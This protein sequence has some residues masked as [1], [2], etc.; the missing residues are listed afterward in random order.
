MN[1][2]LYGCY[3]VN[4]P[5]CFCL[6]LQ[7]ENSMHRLLLSLM[8]ALALAAMTPPVSVHAAPAGHKHALLIGISDYHGNEAGLFPDLNCADDVRQV[9]L[10]LQTTFGF[11]P[12]TDIV[13]LTDPAHTTKVAILSAL[14]TLV[15]ETGPGDLVFIHYSGHGDQVVDHGKA[16]GQ[17]SAIVPCDYLTPPP[18]EKTA[19]NAGEVDGRTIRGYIERLRA[20]KPAQIVLAFDSCHSASAA[21]AG[22]SFKKRGLDMADYAA[23]YQAHHSDYHPAA[24]AVKT[25]DDTE[26]PAQSRG[27]RMLVRG[28]GKS[29][30]WGD[31]TGAGYVVISACRNA[32]CAYECHDDVAGKD[33]G[34]LSYCLARVL[35]QARPDTTYH[36]LFDQV[37]A[38]FRAKFTDQYPQLDGD[39][40]TT[41][42]GG[43]AAPPPASF[44]VSRILGDPSHCHMKAG[45]LQGMTVGSEFT[46]YANS[47]KAFTSDM[48]LGT[49]KIDSLDAAQSTLTLTDR[50]PGFKPEDLDGA[51]AVETAHNYAASPF[52]IDP[53]SIRRQVPDQ[54]Q[55]I[56]DRL[57][58]S[59]LVKAGRGTPAGGWDYVLMR[60]TADPKGRGP[61]VLMIAQAATHTAVKTLDETGV[62]PLAEQI[63]RTVNNQAKYRYAQA[64]G[65]GQLLQN[66]AY[67]VNIRLMHAAS[68]TE[69]GADGK[70]HSII[71]TIDAPVDDAHPLKVGDWFVIQVQNHSP[72]ALYVSLL[73][74]SSAGMGHVDVAWPGSGPGW[75]QESS[76]VP[77]TAADAWTT[78]WVQ[79]DVDRHA[80]FQATT[81]DLDESL[82]VIATHDYVDLSALQTRGPGKG[83]TGP[84]EQIVSPVMRGFESPADASVAPGSWTATPLSIQVLQ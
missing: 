62:V 54:A 71:K 27:G 48:R 14:D 29:S 8:A 61:K 50:K 17:D 56:L 59:G 47:A 49:A 6:K 25:G 74:L 9:S 33:M 15:A 34:R 55:A 37:D 57:K 21:R 13:T 28:P 26:T 2:A 36:Q 7:E 12:K 66:P 18:G 77:V 68:G 52:S 75:T 19:K 70:L 20:K 78:L 46:L 42:L 39:P 11:D 41:L 81:V 23:W 38:L 53:E 65:G 45:P 79:S 16:S 76:R 31:L 44:S 22:T 5:V 1:L 43:T 67:Q 58:E 73:D 51:H 82:K 64:L 63:Y 40:D 69:T 10:A 4:I 80:P 3:P 24:A 72:E 32:D 83:P 35:T 60:E 30:G 84:F